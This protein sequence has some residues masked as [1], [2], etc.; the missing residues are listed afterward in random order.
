MNH[1][2]QSLREMTENFTGHF[3]HYWFHRLTVTDT[4][5]IGKRTM[6]KW[7]VNI[8]QGTQAIMSQFS[9]ALAVMIISLRLA[10]Q[11]RPTTIIKRLVYL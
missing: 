1:R 11:T 3:S 6:C 9:K 7:P 8:Q 10:S 2:F 4:T 5:C